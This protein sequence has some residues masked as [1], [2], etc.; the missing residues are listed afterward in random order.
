MN[1]VKDIRDVKV[2]PGLEGI[3]DLLI[4]WE[5][6]AIEYHLSELEALFKMEQA[7]REEEEKEAKNLT[8]GRMDLWRK[9]RDARQDRFSMF[10]LR[11]AQWAPGRITDDIVE[12]L[13][14]LMKREAV[15]KY[16]A[17]VKRITKITGEKILETKNMHFGFGDINGLVI[18]NNGTAKVTTIGAG[19]Y[20]IQ[21]YHFRV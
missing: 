1:D 2:L 8:S 20:H 9:H 5:G 12:R 13:T 11:L 6:K 21:C 4:E 19:G 3:R 14:K 7:H 10:T 15:D 18:G 16:Y 17:L